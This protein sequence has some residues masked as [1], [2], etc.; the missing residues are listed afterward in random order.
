LAEFIETRQIECL[1]Q[2]ESHT[3][4]SLFSKDPAQFLESDV[5]EQLIINIPFRQ[6]VK[7]HSLKLV[8]PLDNA[9]KVFRTY[10]NRSSTLSFDEA[11]GTEPTEEVALAASSYTPD[12]KHPGLGSVVVPLRFVKYQN[13]HTVTLFVQ[14]NVSDADTTS[15]TQLVLF[16][17][18]VEITK[19]L[20]ELKNQE[21]DDE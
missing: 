3:V 21:H 12:P 17:S 20:K 6:P 5:D 8:A 14:S 4:K 18:P 7:V 19:S 1:N 15:I 2:S 10:V 13:V 16:G 9:P 11:D